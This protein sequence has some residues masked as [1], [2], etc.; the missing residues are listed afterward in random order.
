MTGIKA[1]YQLVLSGIPFNYSAL[2]PFHSVE[3]PWEQKP[4]FP[5][6]KAVPVWVA[7]S[8]TADGSSLP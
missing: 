1:H 2:G 3:R 4:G 6:E 8:E 5:K 7:A